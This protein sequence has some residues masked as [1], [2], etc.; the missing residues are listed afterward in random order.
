LTSLSSVIAAA[1]GATAEINPADELDEGETLGNVSEVVLTDENAHRPR[2]I[3]SL[4]NKK[5]H[6]KM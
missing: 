6:E 4:S 5:M 3:S 2:T 1:D